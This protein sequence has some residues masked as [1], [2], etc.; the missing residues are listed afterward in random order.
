MNFLAH[1]HIAKHCNSNLAG[2]LLGDF[3][4]GDPNK[5]YSDSFLT[6]LG[7][8][9]LLIAILIVM[10]Y[11]VLQNHFSQTKHDALRL[12]HSMYFG[13]TA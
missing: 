2:N 12:S 4:K 10:M 6:A 13:I 5:H 11:L 1:L 7:F 9:D 3:V 8:I